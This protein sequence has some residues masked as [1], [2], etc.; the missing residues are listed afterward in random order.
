MLKEIKKADLYRIADTVIEEIGKRKNPFDE[1]TLVFHS[2]KIAQWFKAYF[3]K[4]ENSVLMNTTCKTLSSFINEIINPGNE[5]HVLTVEEYREYLIRALLTD[6]PQKSYYNDGHAVAGIRLYEFADKLSTVVFNMEFDNEEFREESAEQ[7][8]Q[9]KIYERANAFAREDECYTPKQMYARC[10]DALRKREGKVIVFNNSFV[11]ALYRDILSSVAERGTDILVFSLDEEEMPQERCTVD[12]YAA[13]SKMREVERLH[14]DICQKIRDD[15]ACLVSDFVVFAPNIGDYANTVRRVFQRSA[16]GYPEVPFRVIGEST[17]KQDMPSALDLLNRIAEKGFFT[18]YDLLKMLKI[19]MFMY[20]HGINDDDIEA[21]SDAIEA[22]NT[23]R[24]GE[25]DDW[26]YFK[27]RLLSAAF[28]DGVVKLKDGEYQPYADMGMDA[29]RIDRL[30]DIIDAL[31][32]WSRRFFGV[33]LSEKMLSGDEILALEKILDNLFANENAYGE[34]KNYLYAEVK[35]EVGRIKRIFRE[36]TLPALTFLLLLKDAPNRYTSAPADVFSGGV[37]FLSLGIDQIVPA[38]YVY[39]LRMSSENFPR[40]ES[41]NEIDFSQTHEYTHD[42]DKKA[43]RNLMASAGHIT[44]SF[45]YCDLQT[46]EEFFPSVVLPLAKREEYND[47]KDTFILPL[48]ENRRIDELFTR[49]ELLNKMRI[50]NIGAQNQTPPP[51][52]EDKS[53]NVPK[54]K[55]S[56]IKKYLENAVVYKYSQTLKD[57]EEERAQENEYESID[58]GG[59]ES[60][61]VITEMIRMAITP[62]EDGAFPTRETVKKEFLKKAKLWKKLPRNLE[63]VYF[64]AFYEQKAESVIREIGSGYQKV[65]AFT[66]PMDRW[67]LEMDTSCYCKEEGTN[68]SFIEA[69]NQEK[70]AKYYLPP[71]VCALAVVAG[72]DDDA[73]YKVA[74]KAMGEK[75]F[76]LTSS[77]AKDTLNALA[78]RM[79]D[80]GGIKYMDIELAEKGQP[81]LNTISALEGEIEDHRTWKYFTDK[82]MLNAEKDFGYK[83]LADITPEVREEWEKMRELLLFYTPKSKTEGETENE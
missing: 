6:L 51:P 17:E 74:L 39:A 12:L 8:E 55:T 31:D 45:V 26:Q 28:S 60:Y 20:V 73:E 61:G 35:E 13:P 81:T 48:D 14:S 78:A 69:R 58:C 43:F 53:Q 54:I 30:T 33:D 3:L 32:A 76:S 82:K 79:Q 22:T 1:I 63:E 29:A 75:N 37:T 59:L 50:V 64:D 80:L 5:N 67:V 27:K 52:S 34:E 11:S 70:G 57:S 2:A 42:L 36:G 46:E 19:P 40:T 83:N 72:K 47:K 18:R 65:A 68:L 71:Y 15:R 7:R 23:H 10:R 16:P 9:K 49:R 41:K 25:V 77:L 66:L 21:F 56:Q 4:K 44:A 38:K 24:G 62:G